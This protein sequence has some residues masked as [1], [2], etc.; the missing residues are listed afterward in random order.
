[1]AWKRAGSIGIPLYI[2]QTL[3]AALYIIGFTARWQLGF[4]SHN[5][6]LVAS[7]AGI[8]LLT[9]SYI[10]AHFAMKI[11]FFILAIIGFSLVSF[12]LTKSEPVSHFVLVGD[13]TDAGFWKAFAIFFP[14]VTGIMAGANMS[15]DLKDPKKSI[16][17]GTITS[18]IVTMVVYI[19]VAYLATRIATPEELRSNQMI[20]VDKAFWGPAVILGIMLLINPLFSV[21]AMIII[22]GLYVWLEK[23]GLRS[24]WGDIRGRLFLA[25]AEKASRIAMQFPKHQIT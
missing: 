2:S 16:P 24:N 25:I 23:Q 14:A 19:A 12:F 15:G 11:Q 5:Y 6:Y 1:M 4:P 21:V 20:M 9:A 7:V 17:L 22:I 8:C 3:S 10:S 13:F 18:I